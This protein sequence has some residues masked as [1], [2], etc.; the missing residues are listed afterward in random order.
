MRFAALAF[1]LFQLYVAFTAITGPAPDDD[2]VEVSGWGVRH[3]SKD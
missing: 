3:P 2:P 1:A